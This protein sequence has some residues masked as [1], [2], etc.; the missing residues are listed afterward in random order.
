MSFTKGG[1]HNWCPWKT[2]IT[3]LLI[4]TD[5]VIIHLF[6]IAGGCG[7]LQ[8]IPT[9]LEWQA[10]DALDRSPVHGRADI[11]KQPTMDAL[12]LTYSI[13]RI[14]SICFCCEAPTLATAPPCRPD[15]VM[16]LQYTQIKCS[17]LCLT[18]QPG[19]H[20]W[21]TNYM[22][23]V[24]IKPTLKQEMTLI[25]FASAVCSCILLMD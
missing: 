24:L 4:Y 23:N 16:I 22:Q 6:I 25:P 21:A 9:A 10:G 13:C 15:W 18:W 12:I 19:Y 3:W 20:L 14:W 11:S 1:K 8:P 7:E 17:R 5:W 2:A